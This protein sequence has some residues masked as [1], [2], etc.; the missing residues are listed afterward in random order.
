MLHAVCF[1][2]ITGYSKQKY[3]ITISHFHIEKQKRILI[4][5]IFVNIFLNLINLFGYFF[6]DSK[7]IL[8]ASEKASKKHYIYTFIECTPPFSCRL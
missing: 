6:S 2:Q 4:T 8:I 3:E 7:F 1:D 5:N